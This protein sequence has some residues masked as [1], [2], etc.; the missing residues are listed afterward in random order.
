MLILEKRKILNNLSS[1]LKKL[2]KEDKNKSKARWKNIRAE[3][4]VIGNNREKSIE[5]KAGFLKNQ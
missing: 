2:E 4:N 5:Q 3:I 1:F